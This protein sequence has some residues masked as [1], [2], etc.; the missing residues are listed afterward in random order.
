MKN[1]ISLL[2]LI[3]KFDLFFSLIL[4]TKFNLFFFA[5]FNNKI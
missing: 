3:T 2:I 1:S 4:I 5:N